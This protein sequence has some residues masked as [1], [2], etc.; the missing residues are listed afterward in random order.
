[1]A[2]RKGWSELELSET[3]DAYLEMLHKHNIG[4]PYSKSKYYQDL[5]DKFGRTPK[6]FGRRMSNI[7]HI[8][9]LM[10]LPALSGLAPLTNV[11]PQQAP[12]IE[13]L[14]S[15]KL[16]LPYIGIGLADAEMQ[17]LVKAKRTPKKPSG[18]KKTGFIETTIKV[19]KRSGKVKG[20]VIRRA[21]GSCELCSDDAPFTKEC[22]FR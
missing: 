1:M 10:D 22:V 13:R 11:G 15:E 8:M 9:M 12:I 21:E 2:K 17:S 3:V 19:Y 14:I 7:T 16:K 20:W 5:A 4:T 18:D 6:A